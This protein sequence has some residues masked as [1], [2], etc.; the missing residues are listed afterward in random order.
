MLTLGSNCIMVIRKKGCGVGSMGS[1]DFTWN[2]GTDAAGWEICV[3]IFS[4]AWPR[5]LKN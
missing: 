3:I 5:T 4:N 1:Q 2:K